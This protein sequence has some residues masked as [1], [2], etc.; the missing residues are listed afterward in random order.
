MTFESDKKFD[1]IYAD[2]IYENENLDWIDFYCKKLNKNSI[3][4]IQ[5]DWHT[6]YL[7]RYYMEN[8]KTNWDCPVF[9]NHLVQK[10]EWG[11][12]PKNKFHQCYDD[13]LVFTNG[14]DYKFYPERIQVDKVTKNKGLNPSGRETKQATAWID[15]ICLTTTAKERVKKS[16]GHLVRWQ[17]PIKLFDRIVAPFTDEHDMIIDPFMGVGS[18]GEWCINN[19]RNYVGI[20]YDKEV[21][22][23]AENRLNK[24]L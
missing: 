2:M 12:H 14:K 23:L 19:N 24:V 1:L 15:D 20:E 3:F 6:N 8:Y 7:V 16:D 4:I 13:I 18:L 17:K 11:N 10:N 9:I 21:F 5:T 22:D